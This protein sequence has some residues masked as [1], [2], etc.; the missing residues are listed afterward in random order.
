M[1]QAPA[2]QKIAE[3]APDCSALSCTA[4]CNSLYQS[5]QCWCWTAALLRPPA[6]HP[7]NPDL[8]LSSQVQLTEAKPPLLALDTCPLKTPAGPPSG[9]AP[10][11]TSNR[12]WDTPPM[13]T[14]SRGPHSPAC[15]CSNSNRDLL[16]T[17]KC[18]TRCHKQ[19]MPRASHNR[20]RGLTPLPA[21][22]GCRP[23]HRSELTLHAVH[24][25]IC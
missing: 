18:T 17:L 23:R 2:R 16:C 19:A 10:A 5:C 24:L 11:L 21:A 9:P 20:S 25:A 3:Q 6:R 13:T 4:Q 12:D 1:Q 7:A 15:P 8:C 22:L 14:S